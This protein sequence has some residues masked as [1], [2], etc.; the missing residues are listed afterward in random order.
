MYR[1]QEVDEIIAYTDEYIEQIDWV[2]DMYQKQHDKWEKDNDSVF[3]H[4]QLDEDEPDEKLLFSDGKII[5]ET[6]LTLQE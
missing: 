2:T 1:R 5:I 6:H 3:I 4:W